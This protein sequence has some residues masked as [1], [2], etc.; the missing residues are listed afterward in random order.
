MQ[1]T[2]VFLKAS[3]LNLLI[4]VQYCSYCAAGT[5]YVDQNHTSASDANPG[6]LNSPWLTLRHAAK[7]L[8]AGDTVFVRD[9]IYHEHVCP[10][11]SGN[12]NSPVVYSNYP[13][14]NPVIDGTGVIQSQNAILIDKS[15]I[16]MIGLDVRNWNDNGIWIEN[17]A[18]ISISDCEVHDVFY[19]IGIADGTHDFVFNRVDVHHFDLY[20]FDVSPSGGADCYNGIFNDCVSHSARDPQ[21][22]V[23]GFALGHGTQHDFEC[24]RCST[25]DVYD[26]FDISAYEYQGTID[27]FGQGSIDNVAKSFM[28]YQNFPNPF[29]MGTD[30]YYTLFESEYVMID[31]YNTLGQKIRTLNYGNHEAGRHAIRWNG[32]DDSGY[33]ANSGQYFV[34]LKSPALRQTRK[35]LLIQ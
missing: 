15:Y 25:H 28:L 5:Y 22:N 4:I 27:V 16:T 11:R 33:L 26:G 14:E 30:I 17:A 3:L 31:I 13:G 6:T 34:T 19:G 29:N 2:T 21:Q 7:T 1:S 9:G 10:E 35:M 18:H 32:K 20:G 8:T 12:A 24:N 23:D